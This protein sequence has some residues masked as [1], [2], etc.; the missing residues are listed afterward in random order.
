MRF[1]IIADVDTRAEPVTPEA[2]KEHVLS[3][4]MASD[5]KWRFTLYRPEKTEAIHEPR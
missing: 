2:I 1:T 3:L 4:L 5:K